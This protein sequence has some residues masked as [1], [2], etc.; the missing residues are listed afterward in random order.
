MRGMTDFYWVGRAERFE[1][2]RTPI[3]PSFRACSVFYEKR[4]VHERKPSA[5]IT[6][7]EQALRSRTHPNRGLISAMGLLRVGDKED[8]IFLFLL[9]AK[10]E[11]LVGDRF[12]WMK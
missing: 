5:M 10:I 8:G 1:C 12:L 4:A 2:A 11:I 6:Y 9:S 3:D 7:Y